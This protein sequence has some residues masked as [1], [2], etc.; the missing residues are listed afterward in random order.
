[1]K[2]TRIPALLLALLMTLSFAGCL[3]PE[4]TQATDPAPSAL[5]PEASAD[6]SA[7]D[8]EA[9]AVELGSIQITAGEIEESYNYYVSMLESYYGVAVT[10]DASIS[11]Y[12]EMAV[13]DLVDYYMPMWKASELGVSLTASEQDEIEKAVAE[14]TDQLRTDLICEYAYYYGGAAEIYEDTALLTVDQI[15]GAMEEINAE[16]TEYYYEGY[17]LDQYLQEQYQNSVDDRRISLLSDKLR[18]ASSDTLNVTDEQIEAWYESTLAAQKESFDADA[19]AYIDQAESFANGETDYPA[20]YVPEGILRAKVIAIA[21]EAERDLK[22]ETNRAE[23]ADLEQEYGKLALN[24]VDEARQAEILA[25]YAE[26]KAENE[27]LEE[28]FL[29]DARKAIAKASELLEEE[30]PF[31]EVMQQYNANG[32]TAETLLMDSDDP[33]YG[34]LGFYAAELPDGM[35]SEPLLI[36]DVY[37]IVMPVGRLSAGAVD[38]A[39]IED[40]IKKAATADASEDAWQ[41]LLDEWKTEAE[42]AAVRHEDVYAA[43]GYLG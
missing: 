30:T 39:P 4:E 29:G 23:M 8:P 10:D 19:T 33:R 1:M 15:N 38:R 41:A 12:R 6:T 36:D 9:V 21:P 11:E 40:A 7:Y 25:H 18:E 17:T 5:Q 2:Q 28:A 43:I 34:D 26:L 27:T 32:S 31:D 42:A 16:L 13:N 35:Y 37:Y 3:V 22:I 20:L 24:G 14:E